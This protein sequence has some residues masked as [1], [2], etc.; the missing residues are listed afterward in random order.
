MSAPPGNPD[1]DTDLRSDAGS[2]RGTDR[3]LGVRF[4]AG[5][6]LLAAVGLAVRLA[7]VLVVKHDEPLRGDA[8][9][10]FLQGHQVATGSR[11]VNAALLAFR[12]VSHPAADHPPLFTSY[13]AL[14]DLLDIRTSTAC[15]S[16]SR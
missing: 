4:G 16:A 5:L 6:A 1:T 15:G 8:I 9:T 3:V 11:L 13:L 7:Y 10:F 12:G 2:D 14:L